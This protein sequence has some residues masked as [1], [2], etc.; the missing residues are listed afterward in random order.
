MNEIFLIQR[1]WIDSLENQSSNA[2]GYEPI[3][4]L[5]T[6]KE[7]QD[8]VSKGRMF[9]RADCWAIGYVEKEMPQFTYKKLTKCT[10]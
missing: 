8:F 2:V 9:T 6:E 5:P 3:G 1:I 7:A 10:T 4:W